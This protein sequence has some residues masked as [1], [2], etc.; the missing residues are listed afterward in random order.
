MK[1][2]ASIRFE[3]NSYV[4]NLTHRGDHIANIYGGE[5]KLEGA[6]DI[7]YERY[8]LFDDANNL[9]I[10]LLSSYYDI[11]IAPGTIFEIVPPFKKEE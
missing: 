10:M 6:G 8:S 2:E 3:N 5:L 1:I 9:I 11:K 4:V 7:R